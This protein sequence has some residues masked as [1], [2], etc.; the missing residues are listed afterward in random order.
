MLFIDG[1]IKKDLD[2]ILEELTEDIH[3]NFEFGPYACC[4]CGTVEEGKHSPHCLVT[5]ANN[6]REAINA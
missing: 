3:W 5:L 6:V 4:F 2:A 1:V